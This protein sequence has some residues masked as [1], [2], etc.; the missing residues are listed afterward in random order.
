MSKQLVFI[1][2]SGDPGFKFNRGSSTHFVV[3]CVIFD[4]EID[5]EFASVSIKKLKRDLG[6]K[7]D[8]EFKFNK[9]TYEQRI[10]LLKVARKLDFKARAVVVDKTKLSEKLTTDDAFYRF[11]IRELLARND[12]LTGARVYL[13][14]SAGK[15]YRNRAASYLRREL[16][17]GSR[18]ISGLR[19]VDSKT[20][21]LIQLS[22]MIAGSIRR[23]YDLTKADRHEYCGIIKPKMEDVWHYMG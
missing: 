13:D 14:G 18:K 20:D 12:D 23:K 9:N 3:V 6:W 21:N 22:D 10:A 5:A 11:I 17:K 1:D 19:F 8:H 7:S 4:N 15:D 16:N 2:D